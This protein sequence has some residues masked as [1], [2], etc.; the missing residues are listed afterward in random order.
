MPTCS[1]KTWLLANTD[2]LCKAPREMNFC[3][4]GSWDQAG[5]HEKQGRTAS[6]CH[7]HIV[8]KATCMTGVKTH[9]TGAK[10]WTWFG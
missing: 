2:S 6:L 8:N 10:V 4:M 3:T 5:K 1:K 7:K 9:L